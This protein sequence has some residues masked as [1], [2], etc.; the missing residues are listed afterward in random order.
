MKNHPRVRGQEAHAVGSR[1]LMPLIHNIL[2]TSPYCQVSPQTLRQPLPVTAPTPGAGTTPHPNSRSQTCFSATQITTLCQRQSA[3]TKQQMVEHLHCSF[4]SA[5]LRFFFPGQVKWME[6]PHLAK[7]LP[8][9]LHPNLPPS[10]ASSEI[11]VDKGLL[12]HLFILLSHVR[13]SPPT[14]PTSFQHNSLNF[15]KLSMLSAYSF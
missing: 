2:Q 13:F 1:G 8:W 4:A 14:S 12:T 9:T 6:N 7:K 3:K 15:S 11:P 5:H 10:S